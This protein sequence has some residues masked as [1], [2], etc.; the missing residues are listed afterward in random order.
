MKNP[1]A[2]L[3]PATV[4]RLTPNAIGLWSNLTG[5]ADDSGQYSSKLSALAGVMH[6][7]EKTVSRA[8]KELAAAGIVRTTFDS[9]K[10]KRWH[11]IHRWDAMTVANAA[12][13]R[14][15]RSA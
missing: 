3:D 4:R 7:S 9:Q 11:L 13:A 6:V 12:S 1:P 14:T 10:V 2:P 5:F 8:T 15:R